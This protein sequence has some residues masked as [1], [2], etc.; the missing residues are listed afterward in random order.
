MTSHFSESIL[1]MPAPSRVSFTASAWFWL[2]LSTSILPMNS[3]AFFCMS[4]SVMRRIKFVE[5]QLKTVAARLSPSNESNWLR[6]CTPETM[7]TPYFRNVATASSSLMSPSVWASSK[8]NQNRSSCTASC[9]ASIAENANCSMS[10]NIGRNISLVLESF[11]IKRRESSSELIKSRT[12]QRPDC[13]KLMPS[14]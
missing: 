7:D 14:R 9:L 13:T 2:V 4:G 6:D 10:L 12:V 8:K 3:A 11:K 1:V 5:K